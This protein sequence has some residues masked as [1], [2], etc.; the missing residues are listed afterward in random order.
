MASVPPQRP[1]RILRDSAR[2]FSE[3]AALKRAARRDRRCV[4]C[5]EA[6]ESRR[7]PYCSR[8][9]QWRFQAGYFWDAAR[10]YAIHRDRFTCRACARRFRVGQL[11]VD[12]IVEIARGG[13]PLD[14]ANLQTLCRGCHR[15]KTRAFLRGRARRGGGAAP[16]SEGPGTF[17]LADWFPA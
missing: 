14:P 9:C 15:S 17:D 12:H 5:S 3:G 11:E 1:E 13:A 10:T 16:R 8:L 4:A 7:T 2:W 6:L